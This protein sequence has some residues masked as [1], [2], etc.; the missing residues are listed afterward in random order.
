MSC[1]TNGNPK[2]IYYSVKDVELNPVRAGMV[3]DPAEYV[4]SGYQC[5]AF[6]KAVKM[7]TP[8]GEY[9]RLGNND[10]A[11]QKA[12]RAMFSSHVDDELF[13][14]IRM[15]VNTGLALGAERF[16]EDIER[17]YG[18]RLRPARM[19]RPRSQSKSN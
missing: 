7:S 14:D 8:H 1:K 12:C 19:V 13:K 15:A 11:R 2:S 9:L 10:H 4:W 17:L 3:S 16:K 6:G 5:H 18:R